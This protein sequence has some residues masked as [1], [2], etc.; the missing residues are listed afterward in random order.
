M[1]KGVRVK[2]YDEFN[3][4]IADICEKDDLKMKKKLGSALEKFK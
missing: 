4:K 3:N 1:N 2:I